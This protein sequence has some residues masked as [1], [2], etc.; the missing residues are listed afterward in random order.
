MAHEK[1]S[2]WP[3]AQLHRRF[4]NMRRTLKIV[5]AVTG[6]M[7]GWTMQ[8]YATADRPSQLPVPAHIDIGRPTLAPFAYTQFCLKHARECRANAARKPGTAFNGAS[9]PELEQVNREVND[10]IN[11]RPHANPKL[12]EE[13]TV[14]PKEGDCKDYAATKRHELL[15]RGW[16]SS[17]LRLAEVVTNTGDH[18]L[19]LVV[20][21]QDEDV[22]LDNLHRDIRPLHETNYSWVRIQSRMDPKFWY[23]VRRAPI[24]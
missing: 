6:L 14:H 12:G 23:T 20:R 24:L 5:V 1:I 7:S 8:V 9:R 16:P 10:A 21:L 19:V 3:N 2:S 13:W 11:P 15:L 22:I 4:D 18:H 17:L